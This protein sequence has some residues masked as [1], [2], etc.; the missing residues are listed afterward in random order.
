MTLGPIKIL[1][2]ESDIGEQVHVERFLRGFGST[3]RLHAV[4]DTHSALQ[5]LREAHYDVVLVDYRFSDGT[6]FDLLEQSNDVPVVFLTEEGQ[7][8]TAALALKRGAYDYLIKDE[9]RNYLVLL[10]GTIQK[11]LNR[12]RTELALQQYEIRCRDLMDLMM[13]IYMCISEEGAVLLVNKAGAKQ[14]GYSS[15]EMIGVPLERLLHPDDIEIVKRDMMKAAGLPDRTCESR[16]RFVGRNGR[17]LFVKCEIRM[18]PEQGK[19]IP[20]L[21]LVGRV[22][23]VSNGAQASNGGLAAVQ[24]SMGNGRGS[25]LLDSAARTSCKKSANGARILIVDANREQRALAARMLAKLGYRVVTA[26]SG[27]SALTLMQAGA[28]RNSSPKSPFDLVLLDVTM[29][30]A[31]ADG[32]AAFRSILDT[33]PRHPCVIMSAAP[34]DERVAEARRL[35]AVTLIQKPYSMEDLERAVRE[36]LERVKK[37]IA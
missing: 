23:S 27:H 2:V 26:E 28:E 35:G 29:T 25:L 32:L 10:P 6:V 24:A 34:D 4:D 7:E 14:L 18:Q 11:V 21:R 3:Y 37:A 22:M 20:V 8:A 9:N 17:T 13:D 1:F 5:C 36:E 30:D 19:Q 15:K 16:F 31:T 12:R 33:F